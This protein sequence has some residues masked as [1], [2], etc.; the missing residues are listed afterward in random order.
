MI[1]AEPRHDL[2]EYAPGFRLVTRCTSDGCLLRFHIEQR[3]HMSESWQ[4]VQL[5]WLESRVIGDRLRIE[6]TKLMVA[7]LRGIFAM[8]EHPQSESLQEILARADESRHV[9][10]SERVRRWPANRKEWYSGGS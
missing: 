3:E 5:A 7:A 1:A 9:S 8:Y 10:V 2:F 6:G 4:P